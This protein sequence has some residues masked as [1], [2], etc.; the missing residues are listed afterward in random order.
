[1]SPFIYKDRD[2]ITYILLYID[3]IILMMSSHAL[4]RRTTDRLSSK[5]AMTNLGTLHHFLGIF[6]TLF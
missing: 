5:F 6:V 3:D 1:M 4:L 2:D